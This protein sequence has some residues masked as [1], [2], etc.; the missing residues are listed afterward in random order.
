MDKRSE[1]FL[2]LHIVT[3][4]T[5]VVSSIVLVN[6]YNYEIQI[7]RTLLDVGLVLFLTLSLSDAFSYVRG[8]RLR[9]GSTANL[10]KFIEVLNNLT[11][12]VIVFDGALKVAFVSDKLTNLFG[13]TKKQ[14][15]TEPIFD[16][17]GVDLREVVLEKVATGA[18]I[19]DV[20][21]YNYF[22]KKLSKKIMFTAKLYSINY[23]DVKWYVLIIS[24][25]TDYINEHLQIASK[26]D[27]AEKTAN[28]KTEFL[29]RVSHEIR[30]PLN[31][32]IG[33]N[34]IAKERL[35]DKDYAALDD[36]LDKISFSSNYLLSIVENVL[37]MS[38]L[39]A[40]KVNPDNKPFSL[41]LLL[42]EISVV[43]S[44][45]IKKKNF[46]YHVVKNFDE[47]Y[48]KADQTKL[49]QIIINILG[50][51]IKYTEENGK[52]ILTVLA[53]DLIDNKVELTISIKDNGIGMSEEF[54]KHMFEPFSQEN[55]IKGVP[56]TGLGLAITKSL[57][58]LLNGKINVES[59]E[60][61]GTN[62]TLTFVFDKVEDEAI[63]IIELNDYD[64]V[65][66][67][68]YKVLVAEDNMINQI[69]IKDHLQHFKFNIEIV[70]DGKEALDKFNNSPI[71]T[72]DFILMDIH[73][74]HMDGY[75]A[76]KAI[77]ELNRPDSNLP[78]IALTADAMNEDVS[79]ALVN[80][81]NNHIAKPVIRENMIKTIY[82]TLKTCGKIN[83]S[84]PFK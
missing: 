5:Y 82:Q 58:T 34:Q 81:M 19:E 69:V 9:I 52:I 18:K 2:I 7:I 46:D 83:L 75:E 12:G 14:I 37:N 25:N 31:G 76:T 80:K 53:K 36:T 8:Y 24:D 21:D 57:I 29:S 77:R 35:D 84:T 60:N 20:M 48:I 66:Y 13:L 26:L 40:G 72:Y 6:Y 47:L 51:S 59:K 27:E 39:E 54:T 30:T 50:N 3:A 71:N 11:E 38:R 22:N 1:F 78:I 16:M 23:T 43:V 42:N 33:M 62:T 45:Q 32:I 55:K 4:I 67:S 79:K 56:S 63:N 49:T 17:N 61:E 74:P 15:V 73:M 10:T 68:K 64:L 70:S 41:N 65:D 44:P 28:E